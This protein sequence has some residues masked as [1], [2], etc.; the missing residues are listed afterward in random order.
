M[1][2]LRHYTQICKEKGCKIRA[3]Y[4]NS[5]KPTHCL[6]HKKDGMKDVVSFMCLN[7][8]EIQVKKIKPYLC[9]NCNPDSVKLK[10]EELCRKIFNDLTGK[11]FVSC[12][13]KWL[14]R[15]E[16]DGYCEELN[17]AF[18]YNGIQHY[19]YIPDFFH[20]EGINS[21][22]EQILRD[23]RKR[24]LCNERGIT[25]HTIPYKYKYNDEEGM[26]S[27]IKMIL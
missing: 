26:K 1:I 4:S 12:R 10:S 2:D 22:F 9:Y 13:P 19:K 11:K 24:Y 14:E 17:M 3:S 27:Y 6:K 16:L 23:K 8:G 21:F 18:E 25:L 20:K 5:K 15:L 7:C